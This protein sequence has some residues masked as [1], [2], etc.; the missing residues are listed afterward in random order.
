MAEFKKQGVDGFG[1][2][3]FLGF[4]NSFE[5]S[6]FELPESRAAVVFI[7]A[8]FESASTEMKIEA[9][10]RLVARGGVYVVAWGAGSSNFEDIVDETAI[11]QGLSSESAVIMTTSHADEQLTEALEFAVY[12][13]VPD[14]A[15][16]SA[17]C[18]VL[19]FIGNV[20]W[21]NEAHNLLAKR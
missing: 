2:P 15:Y 12:S 18:V 10:S 20:N 8:D 13:T 14:E 17:D 21:Y 1:R 9:A 5:Q 3:V 11:E 6:A 19:L 7:G 16:G 4:S